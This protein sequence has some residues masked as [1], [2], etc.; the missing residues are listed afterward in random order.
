MRSTAANGKTLRMNK[1]FSRIAVLLLLVAFVTTGFLYRDEFQVETLQAWIE[2]AGFAAPLVFVCIY[3]LA[4]VAFIPGS[5]I[6]LAGGALFGPLWGTLWNLTGATLGAAFAFLGA[7]YLGA[8]WLERHSGKRLKRLADGVASEGWRFVAFVRLVPLLPFNL[9]NYALGLTRIR[10][11][12]YVIATWLFMIPGA[13]AYT[14]LGYVGREAAA[15]GEDLIHKG[16]IA[17]ALLAAV[18]FL[19]RLIALLRGR[20]MLE[21]EDLK[22]RLDAGDDLL[23]L[24]VRTAEDFTGEQGHLAAARNLPLEKLEAGIDEL[25]PWMEKPVA[26]ICRTDRRSVKA[27]TLLIRAGFAD[28]KVIRG[29]MTAWLSHG[30]PVVD[31]SQGSGSV[32]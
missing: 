29:G 5:V 3:A 2:D 24:D 10:F 15:G 20:P 11:L 18:L 32:G 25:E 13:L 23:V 28:V 19:P 31:A 9:L 6:T 27:A 17:L 1:G 8:D 26:I 22:Q 12:P 21:I 30:W 4:T 7:R 14:Y 16:L